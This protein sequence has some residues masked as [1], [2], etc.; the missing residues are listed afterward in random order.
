MIKLF[1]ILLISVLQFQ[2][3]D[4]LFSS[5]AT[6]RKGYDTLVAMDAEAAPGQEKSEVLW[7]L[8]RACLLIGE[9]REGKD[10]KR[11]WFV[12][13][14]DYGN[15]AIKENPGSEQCY[16]WHSANVGR[17][18]QTR[19]LKDQAAAVPVMMKDLETILVKL[20][21]TNCSEAWQ[22]LSEIYVNHPFKS[23]DSGINFAR[24]AAMTVPSDELRLSSYAY[25]AG[26]LRKR[27]WT[28]SKR[29]SQMERSAGNLAGA[30]TAIDKTAIL[31]GSLGA[32]YKPVWSTSTLGEMS[33]AQEADAIIGWAKNKFKSCKNPSEIDKADFSK[34]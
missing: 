26:L 30:A 34:L 29:C 4:A 25:L 16:M 20:G 14:I 7:R 12:K 11:E 22:A 9:T 1:S 27:D 19:S 32:G 33:D 31:D 24:K 28:A 23:T 2:Q 10:A 17:D 6:F 21:K 8:S 3:V 5:E 13:G 15:R 18:C